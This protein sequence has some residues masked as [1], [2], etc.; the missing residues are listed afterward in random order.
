MRPKYERAEKNQVECK[1]GHGG[2]EGT[3]SMSLYC[4]LMGGQRGKT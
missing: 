3:W 4:A 1:R 2:K